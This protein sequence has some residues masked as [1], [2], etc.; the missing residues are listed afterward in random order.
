MLPV[1]ESLDALL[2]V[3]AYACTACACT[4]PTVAQVQILVT[5]TLLSA[6]RRT[7]TAAVRAVGLGGERHFTT[8]HWVLNRVVWS[9]QRLSRILLQLLVTTLLARDAPLVLLIDGTLARPWGTKIALKWRSHD[10]VRSQPGHVV[11]TEG[12]HWLCLALL[13]PRPWGAGNGPCQS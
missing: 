1:S 5:G 10:A 12:M 8:Y 6:G 13:V 11:T 3:F 9:P 7:V 2:C 4:R